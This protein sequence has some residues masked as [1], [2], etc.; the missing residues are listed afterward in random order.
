MRLWCREI[1][2]FLLP[3]PCTAR[4]SRCHKCSF[5][6][7][8]ALRAADPGSA[9]QSARHCRSGGE[10]EPGPTSGSRYRGW[11]PAWQAVHAP[12]RRALPIGLA[13]RPI[14]GRRGSRKIPPRTRAVAVCTQQREAVPE[15]CHT[16]DRW[17]CVWLQRGWTARRIT[18]N[19]YC[20]IL[21][22]SADG[23]KKKK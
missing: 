9:R 8:S 1:G 21:F 23:I 3:A 4:L 6:P 14:S 10:A 18:S 19:R 2:L 5:C 22:K 13:C 7:A 20:F 12:A 16:L 15:S 17:S 11:S